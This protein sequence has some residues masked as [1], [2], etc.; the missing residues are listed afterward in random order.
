[1]PRW[2]ADQR[3]RCL[4]TSGHRQA[5]KD[6]EAAHG[7]LFLVGIDQPL[8]RRA[9]ELAEGHSLRGYDAVHLASALALG[10]DAVLVTWDQRPQ[11]AARRAGCPIAPP[12]V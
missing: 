5:L 4:T 12:V 1:M 3:A 2:R 7:E 9:G 8:A 11:T 10:E 6:L